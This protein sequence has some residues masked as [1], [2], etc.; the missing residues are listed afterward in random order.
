MTYLIRWDPILGVKL[1]TDQENHEE[2]YS[3][4]QLFEMIQ[5]SN[6]QVTTAVQ[7]LSTQLGSLEVELVETRTKIR[8]YNGLRDDV[9]QYAKKVDTIEASLQAKCE[10][11]KNSW[12]SAR[13]IV[14]ILL[15]LA[16]LI[17]SRFKI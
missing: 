14:M 3:N 10:G 17:L 11:S 1:L 15:M 13:D 8:D 16:T 7:S 2:W 12:G 4:K 9:A 6:E 5:K